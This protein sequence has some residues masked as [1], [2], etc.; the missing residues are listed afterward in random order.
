MK[1]VPIPSAG[2]VVLFAQPDVTSYYDTSTTPAQYR[3]REGAPFIR[4]AIIT[5]VDPTQPQCVN[6]RVIDEKDADASGL[7]VYK[8]AWYGEG[9]AGCWWWPPRVE[10]VM[11][12]E[13]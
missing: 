5:E 12:V 3:V 6:L 1:T 9:K 8:F 7:P 11:E 13:S 4:P 10:G 2:R